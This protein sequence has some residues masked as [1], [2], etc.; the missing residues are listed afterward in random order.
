MP[1]RR[2]FADL[3]VHS[4]ASDG[5][6]S[7]AEIVRRARDLGLGAVAVADHDTMQGVAEATE[8]G[9]R[10]EIEVVPAVEINTDTAGGGEVHIL[11]YF[12]D[13][14]EPSLERELEALRQSRLL[15]A[16]KMVAKLRALGVAL[17]L[18]RVL[19]MAGAGTLGRPHLA[20]AIVE[21]GSAR[22]KDEAFRRFLV[23]GAAGYVPREKFE[24][25]DAVGA[26]HRAGGIAAVAHP[27]KA[28]GD[29]VVKSLVV[30]G[31]EAVEA[32]HV[33]HTPADERRWCAFAAEHGLLVVGGS[34]SHGP[35]AIVDVEI[36]SSG[37][38]RE[39]Y[40]AFR[41]GAALILEARRQPSH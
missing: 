39:E 29:A 10:S 2:V 24:S 9:T 30:C 19:E 37:L 16:E 38:T 3:H 1:E 14:P 26:V 23:R 4:R 7:A 33:D 11:G 21:A 8:E 41:E 17:D 28:P 35:G 5:T 22:S 36:G 6:L 32:Y 20:Q 31:L 18:S 25:T 27:Q 40:V 12:F 34:D 15:R 13:S